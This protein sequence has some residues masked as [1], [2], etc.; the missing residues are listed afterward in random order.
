[1]KTQVKGTK[2]FRK[3][4]ARDSLGR[5]RIK[6]KD[7]LPFPIREMSAQLD[8]TPVVYA[9]RAHYPAAPKELRYVM[10]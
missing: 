1:M 3:F 2:Y 7:F 6:E 5:E 8:K 9:L 4:G 10:V